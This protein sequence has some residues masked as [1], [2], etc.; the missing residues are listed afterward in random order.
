V[1]DDH[2]RVFGERFVEP[3]PDQAMIVEIEAAGDDDLG[4]GGNERILLGALPGG[5]KITAVDHR[6]GEVFMGHLRS[7]SRSPWRKCMP[8][9]VVRDFVAKGFHGVS[10]FD[11]RLSFGR[12]AL[13]SDRAHLG[14]V[15]L[16]LAS[17]LRLFVAVEFARD[18]IDREVKQIDDR[19][20]QIFEVGFEP[21]VREG[22]DER[23][24]EDVGDG[25]AGDLG[26]GRRPR[27]GFAFEW[28]M[29][30]EL[31]FG[32]Q[33]VGRRGR[34]QRFVGVRVDRGSKSLA[35]PVSRGRAH[36]GP[37]AT[38]GGG[39]PGSAPEALAEGRSASGR[40]R[41]PTILPRD[42]ERLRRDGK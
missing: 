6:G 35:Y 4:S 20:Q 21:R 31:E 18:A 36:R 12:E 25:S 30:I 39:R 11:E 15:L 27:V 24:V 1:H 2:V 5:E 14:A 26:I 22:G 40:W 32:E 13:Q 9:V 33:S 17:P 38:Q 41:K 37:P 7:G 34:V 10:A 19:P 23:V 8:L 3:V 28:S 42:V 16:L 29:S